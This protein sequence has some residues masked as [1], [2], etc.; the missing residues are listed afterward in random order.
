[1]S[2]NR[3]CIVRW[4]VDIDDATTPHQAAQFARELQSPET[5]ALTF[6]VHDEDG[7]FMETV[8]LLPPPTPSLIEQLEDL[9]RQGLTLDE[10]LIAFVET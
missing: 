8:E 7:N 4:E 2:N 5:H 10:C 3:P 1:M 9:K 6:T